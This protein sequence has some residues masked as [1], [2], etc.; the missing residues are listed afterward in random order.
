ME[1]GGAGGEGVV[2][3]GSLAIAVIG[4][5]IV[6]A[7]GRLDDVVVRGGAIVD[8]DIGIGCVGVIRDE[9]GCIGV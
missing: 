5:W 2:V 7:V 1:S 8:A 6:T 4:W 3:D 9:G